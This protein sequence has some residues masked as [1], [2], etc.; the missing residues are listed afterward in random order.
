[1]SIFTGLTNCSTKKV[2]KKFLDTFFVLIVGLGSESFYEES[3]KDNFFA[4]VMFSSSV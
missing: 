1:M 2:L 3:L 4:L